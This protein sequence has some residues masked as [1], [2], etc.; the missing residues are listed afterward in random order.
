M[1]EKTKKKTNLKKRTEKKNGE[2]F[3]TKMG[4]INFPKT[5]F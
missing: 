4:M 3:S 1:E 2:L 5:I